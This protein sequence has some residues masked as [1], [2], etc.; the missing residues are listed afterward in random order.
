MCFSALASFAS[1][2]ALIA[3]GAYLASH[4]N[5]ENHQRYLA[6]VPGIFGIQ[7]LIEG[8]VWIG[9][10]GIVPDW[11]HTF[12]IYGFSFFATSFWPAF[13]PFAVYQYEKP[14]RESHQFRT[15]ALQLLMSL[16]LAI[17]LYLLW[18]S[19]AYSN[20][21]AEVRCNQID[22]NSIGYRYDIPYLQQYINLI[23]LSVIV[24][25]FALSKNNVVRYLVCGAFF[26]SFVL[27]AFLAK[28]T[29]FPSIWCFLAAIMSIC[30]VP[31]ITAE[32]N[33]S[34]QA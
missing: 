27:A 9:F 33:E 21:I 14:N 30:I 15:R 13:I 18:S 26:V 34:V 8:F 17:S 28:A 7:Q 16:G 3:T 4:K 19:T 22:C 24:I 29:T 5:C 1:G 25:P 20:L 12:A 23:Y 2:T 11:L 10:S 6:L 32:T 31:A